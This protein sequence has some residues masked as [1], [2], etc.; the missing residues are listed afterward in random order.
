MSQN[1]F[2]CTQLNGFK[3]SYLT[4]IVL[5]LSSYMVSSRIL[6][7]RKGLN[8]SIWVTDGTLTE[9]TIRSQRGLRSNCNGEVL[10]IL[11]SSRTG[12]SPSEGLVS[13]QNI[14]WG[15]SYP[16]IEMQLAYSTICW[17]S[18]QQLRKKKIMN[19]IKERNE[20]KKKKRKRRK[21]NSQRKIKQKKE[22]KKKTISWKEWKFEKRERNRKW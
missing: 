12:A 13:Y 10:H 20:Q 15:G 18:W 7:Y 8:S 14:R 21:D 4:L 2:V 17:L 11:Q 3:Y 16:S 6:K 19:K 9:T 1:P 22:R 5:F